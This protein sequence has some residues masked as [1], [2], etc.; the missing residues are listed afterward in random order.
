[1][2]VPLL[3]IRGL[4]VEY[5]RRRTVSVAVDN[6]SFEVPAGGTVGV[7]GESGSGKTTVTRAVLGLA[8]VRSGE[9]RLRGESITGLDRAGLRALYREVQ[10]VF[11]D[12][13]SSLNPSLPVGRVLAE[14]LAAYGEKDK[15]RLR[16][17]VRE[18]LDR[19]QLPAGTENRY[20][21]EL[22]GGQRQRVAIARALMLSP[23]LVI[24]DE[25]LSALDLSAQAQIL[26]LLRELQASAGLS[27]L[28]ISHDLDVVR[29]LCDRVV[30]LYQGRVLEAGQA[31]LVARESAHPYTHMLHEASP[32]PDPRSQRQR[33]AAQAAAARPR[34]AGQ[35]PPGQAD[36]CNFAPRCPFAVSRCW[37]ERPALRPARDGATAACHRFPE[38][39][40]ELPAGPPRAVLETEPDLE[41]E[42][43]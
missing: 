41:T 2:T 9:I 22:S 40:A 16:E 30:V 18:M 5:R 20:P 32:V 19:V 35:A 8:P 17:R 14:P 15:A 23:R 1:M 33:H 11:Q 27:Y 43:A 7:V 37:T 6:V 34:P 31:G 26:N 39:R 25:P 3:E 29:Y 42:R 10:L 28:F 21:R 24:L 36:Q 38:W 4:S 12:P 13:Y